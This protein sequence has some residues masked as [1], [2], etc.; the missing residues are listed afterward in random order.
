M[1]CV[2][3]RNVKFDVKNRNII[4]KSCLLIKN[5]FPTGE[6]NKSDF[7]EVDT[8]GEPEV[9]WQHLMQAIKELKND[10]YH[11]NTSLT[12]EKF[13]NRLLVFDRYSTSIESGEDWIDFDITIQYEANSITMIAINR[14]KVECFRKTYVIS[15]NNEGNC[16]DDFVR[17]G[18]EPLLNNIIQLTDSIKSRKSERVSAVE[19][20]MTGCYEKDF[21]QISLIKQLAEKLVSN[22]N[23][24]LER[25]SEFYTKL[26]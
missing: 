24:H 6:I 17:R 15:D 23:T 25:I 10:E 11:D 26:Y 18:V 5:V 1:R 2:Y 21:G 9:V 14:D 13:V 20:H 12:F 22:S 4:M 16:V 7:I 3:C 8:G 19:Y